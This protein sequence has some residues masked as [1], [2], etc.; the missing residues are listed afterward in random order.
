MTR[1][2]PIH[3]IARLRRSPEGRGGFTLVEILVVI[4][5]IA[6]MGTLITAVIGN[7][8]NSARSSATRATITKVHQLLEERR[9]A[10][11]R[12]NLRSE[13][14]LI[15]QRFHGLQNVDLARIVS[16]KEVLKV[17]IPQNLQDLYGPDRL[18]HTADDSPVLAKL[19]A[20]TPQG[21]DTNKNG[22]LDQGEDLNGNNVLDSTF[23]AVPPRFPQRHYDGNEDVNGNGIL[24]NGE[25]SNGNGILDLPATGSSELLYVALTMGTEL[26]SE[27]GAID[28]TSSEAVDTDQDGLMELVDGWGHPLRFYRWPTRLLQPFIPAA[29]GNSPPPPVLRRDLASLLIAGLPASDDQ[30]GRDPDDPFGRFAVWLIQGHGGN[31]ATTTHLHTPSIYHVPLVVSAGQD[32]LIG[33][34]EP[35]DTATFGHLAQPLVEVGGNSNWRPDPNNSTLNDNITNHNIA[36]GGN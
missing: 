22:V 1:P 33:L 18:P 6:I 12:R 17:Q 19:V 8:L 34:F 14:K 7:A 9:L 13:V 25:D 32:G 23:L 36:I 28:F 30:L 31:R 5:I 26:G 35:F 20:L 15:R 29:Q 10:I 3:T 2:F 21:E 16:K 4:L 24:D 11:S 27:G